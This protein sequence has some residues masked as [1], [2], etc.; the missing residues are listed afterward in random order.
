MTREDAE[1]MLRQAFD[2]SDLGA[3]VDRCLHED[4]IISD[5]ISDQTDWTTVGEALI[6]WLSQQLDDEGPD[7]RKYPYGSRDEGTY[8][9]DSNE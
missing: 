7:P 1:E 8:R 5:A 4:R 9:R 6:N 3:A 2:A